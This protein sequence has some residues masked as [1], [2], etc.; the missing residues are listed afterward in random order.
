M[1]RMTIRFHELGQSWTEK[2]IESLRLFQKNEVTLQ[3]RKDK[4]YLLSMRKYCQILVCSTLF[5]S[6]LFL[7]KRAKK[8]QTDRADRIPVGT[9]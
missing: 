5:F 3:H 4:N 9:E 7:P 2:V 1:S 6:A 8:Q